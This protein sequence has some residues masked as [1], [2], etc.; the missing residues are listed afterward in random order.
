M[1]PHP[2]SCSW[3]VVQ[4]KCS[5]SCCYTHKIFNQL[6]Q[7]DFSPGYQYSWKWCEPSPGHGLSPAAS[8]PRPQGCRGWRTQP[9]PG[10]KIGWFVVWQ[11]GDKLCTSVATCEMKILLTSRSFL[12]SLAKEIALTA[13]SRASPKRDWKPRKASYNDFLENK[14]VY[15]VNGCYILPQH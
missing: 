6:S 4:Q 3:K 10:I 9:P 14:V 13:L 11:K 5:L 8:W 7:R 15:Y 1:L 2:Y 12:R